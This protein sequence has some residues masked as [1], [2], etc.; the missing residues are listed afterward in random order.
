LAPYGVL[1]AIAGGVALGL[2]NVGRDHPVAAGSMIAFAGLY[3]LG[4]MKGRCLRWCRSPFGF[5]VH[6]GGDARSPS[7]AVVLGARHGALCFGCC[8]GLMVGFMG[9]GVIS[10]SWLVAL[11]LLML[12]EKTHRAGVA[13]ARGSGVALLV[14][15]ALTALVPLGRLTSE[16]TGLAAMAAVGIAALAIRWSAVLATRRPA[17][18]VAGT[19]A[20]RRATRIE[21]KQSFEL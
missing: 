7:G 4:T 3:Q 9:A 1:W 8:A 20:F 2:W 10:I 17:V 5:L 19:K 6:F 11:G 21:P 13:L 18:D 15:G 16:A 14:L 12:L